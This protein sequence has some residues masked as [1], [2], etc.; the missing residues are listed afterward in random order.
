[1]K[2]DAGR[3]N[4]ELL[5]SI[6][7][8]KREL[9]R[10]RPF[11]P[12]VVR[13]LEE[14]FRLEWTYNSNAIEGNTLDLRETE[15][16]LHH[17]VTIGKKS[18]KEHFEVINHAAAI[19]EVERF[20]VSKRELTEDLILDLHHL[21]LKNI[22][23][24]EAGRF[25]QHNVRMMGAVHIPPQAKKV[26]RLVGELLAW[27]HSVRRTLPDTELAARVHHQMVYMHPFTDGNGRTARLVMNLLLMREG[28]PP[29]VILN[30]DRKRYYYTLQQADADKSGPF[31]DFIG[32]SV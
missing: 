6:E 29:A 4:P 24:E 23:N 22:D 2:T 21:I 30:V 16:V 20:I 13:R 32:R 1:M 10:R 28:Y 18:L 31:I 27:Y 3:I 7:G 5:R 12:S 14:Q 25:R 11:P 15:M 26:Q 8:K 19:A 17:G 9:D